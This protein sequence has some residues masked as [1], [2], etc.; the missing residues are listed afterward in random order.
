MGAIIVGLT[1]WLP[2]AMLNAWATE[3]I[4]NWYL[5]AVL[6][7][8][9][10]SFAGAFGVALVASLLTARPAYGEDDANEAL[11]KGIMFGLT[12]PLMSVGAAWVY[13][14]IWPLP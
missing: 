5:P 14:A 12:M 6:G 11:T 4:W 13:L 2:L 1:V 3:K 7:A 8:P 10:I 9:Q